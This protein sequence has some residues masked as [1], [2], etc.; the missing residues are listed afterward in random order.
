M[1]NSQIKSQ[2]PR[3]RSNTTR[4]KRKPGGTKVTQIHE[5]DLMK[6]G[7]VDRYHEF[8]DRLLRDPLRKLGGVES[9]PSSWD[10][11][12]CMVRTSPPRKKNACQERRMP[13]R[14]HFASHLQCH[15]N[16]AGADHE[17][18]QDQWYLVIHLDHHNQKSPELSWWIEVSYREGSRARV[19]HS[20]TCI[21]LTSGRVTVLVRF[22][23]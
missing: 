22:T 15:T 20:A 14:Q 9:Q 13:S 16:R 3:I 17:C 11:L 10:G 6:L 12:T 8:D 2:N 1:L 4:K 19:R 5:P 7:R 18:V 23:N 21:S